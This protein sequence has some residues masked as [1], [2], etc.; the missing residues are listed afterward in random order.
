MTQLADQKRGR[1]SAIPQSSLSETDISQH[2]RQ[3]RMAASS[4]RIHS[5]TVP[6]VCVSTPPIAMTLLAVLFRRSAVKLLPSLAFLDSS[7]V[8]DEPAPPADLRDGEE[9]ISGSEAS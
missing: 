3:S 5:G 7:F 4:Q 6:P 2:N 8:H 9:S 1:S